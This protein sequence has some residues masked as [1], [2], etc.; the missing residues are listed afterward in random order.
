V[1][2]D[3]PT[4]AHAVQ[5]VPAP[6]AVAVVPAPHDPEIALLLPHADVDDP[7]VSIVVPAVNEELTITDFVAWCRQGLRD[8]GAKGEILIVDSSTDRTAELALAGGA[9]VLRTPRRGLG[10]AYIDALPFI[11]GTYV[12]MGDA[13]C[14]YD[15][16]ML[17]NFVEKLRGGDDFAMGSRWLGTIEPGSMPGLHRYLGTPVTTW[18]L[19][20]LYGSHFTDIHCGMRGI[21][22]DALERMGLV[23]QSW[24]Y[25]SEM[26]LKSVRMNLRTSEVPVTFYKDREGRM[27]HHKRSGWFSPFQ[28]A[29][30][31]LRAMFVYRAE[32]FAL[33]PGL[34]LLIAGLILTLPLSFGTI[35]V[36]SVTFSL[37]WMLLGVTVAVLGLQ[38][39][40]FGVL[41]QVF[42]DYSGDARRRWTSFFRYTPS[43]MVSLA[44][45]LLGL[46][47]TLALVVRY[48]T[49]H[50]SLPPP[51]SVLDHLAVT[52]SLLM[53]IGFSGFCFTLLL[54][55]TG[56]RYGNP[57]PAQSR[58]DGPA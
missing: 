29:W 41:A 30:I 53:I 24:E 47:L 37:Y 38:S 21:T 55:A 18:I 3:P 2:T 1:E 46:G 22:R 10:R 54:H 20:R 42:C 40:F 7:E 26:V 35:T 15:F 43:I 13:D 45:L 12:V 32:F 48:V 14:T 56:V 34:V 44:L 9:R 49:H 27:S 51:S 28:A 11:R 4:Q 5:P 39:F 57:L 6:G 25:A 19:N 36:G 8:A 16:R 17:G 58:G 31:N 52:G 33:K 23:S 50:F